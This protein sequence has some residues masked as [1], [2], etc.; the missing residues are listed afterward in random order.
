MRKILFALFISTFF[1]FGSFAS[2]SVVRA[3][4]EQLKVENRDGV[5]Y[6]STDPADSPF[7]TQSATTSSSLTWGMIGPP[8]GFFRDVTQI[9]NS[10]LRLV[11]AIA[12]LLVFF[13]LIWAGF[14][15]ITSGGEKGKTE[16]ARN[17]IIS[18]LIG[19]LILASSY[20]ILTLALRFLGFGDINQVLNNVGNVN[21]RPI[22]TSSAT[23]TTSSQLRQLNL[24]E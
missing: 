12:A 6:V 22:A 7:A 10:G 8:K 5:M 9:I 13:Y 23:A 17:R 24:V 3:S 21:S 11:L 14:Q 1:I 20:A 4:G 2:G 15:W 18:A 19:L 16:A